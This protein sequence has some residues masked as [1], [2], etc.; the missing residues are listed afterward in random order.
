M[1]TNDNA[2]FLI[3]FKIMNWKAQIKSDSL[4]AMII[5]VMKKFLCTVL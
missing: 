1:R 3:F 4:L 2:G 5:T